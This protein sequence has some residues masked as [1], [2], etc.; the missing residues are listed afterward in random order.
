MEVE[1]EPDRMRGPGGSKD[2]KEVVA[3]L[4]TLQGG[5]RRVRWASEPLPKASEDSASGTRKLRYL[6]TRYEGSD[7]SQIGV[8]VRVKTKFGTI[9]K[10]HIAVREEGK[11]DDAGS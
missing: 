6:G 2:V 4:P 3:E 7:A 5:D 11:P 8:R 10:D 9:T 1:L